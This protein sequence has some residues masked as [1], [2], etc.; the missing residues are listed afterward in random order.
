LQKPNP[1]RGTSSQA[2]IVAPDDVSY[3]EGAGPVVTLFLSLAK[4]TCPFGIEGGDVTP[5]IV[6]DSPLGSLFSSRAEPSPSNPIL[7][8]KELMNPSQET[9]VSRSD[10]NVPPQQ[11]GTNPPPQEMKVP[12]SEL[13]FL[14][15]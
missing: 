12:W 4:T 10:L 7:H 9:R 3:R 1:G 14:Q 6:D 5:L 2:G 13:I 15:E 11:D 8:R